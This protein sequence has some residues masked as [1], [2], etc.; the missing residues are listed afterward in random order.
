MLAFLVFNRRRILGSRCTH[1]IRQVFRKQ[2]H[3]P[4]I[5][6]LA[7]TY[8]I[9]DTAD[10]Q[11]LEREPQIRIRLAQKR[12][13]VVLVQNHEFLRVIQHVD[14]FAQELHAKAVERRNV[15]TIIAA[16][17]RSDALFHFGSRLVRERHTE[18]IRRRNAH[19]LHEIQIAM[20]Q[21]PS[22]TRPRPSHHAHVALSCRNRLKLLL[23]QAGTL[24]FKGVFNIFAFRA[25]FHTRT[26]L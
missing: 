16:Q 19:F 23:V 7:P 24:P 1:L 9:K 11:I 5:I 4:N 20:R 8:K 3:I 17:N 14:F 18:N 10:F 13:L 6:R 22:F 26:A 15:A 12:L 2:R 25:F 21:R